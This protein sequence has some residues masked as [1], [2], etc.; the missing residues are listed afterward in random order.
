MKAT[1]MSAKYAYMLS[2]QHSFSDDMFKYLV[3]KYED[4]AL[5]ASKFYYQIW[6]TLD[7]DATQPNEYIVKS[8]KSVFL[9]SNISDI[10]H[11][12]LEELNQLTPQEKTQIN[13]KY[14]TLIN[15]PVESVRDHCTKNLYTLPNLIRMYEARY[16]YLLIPVILDY[17]QDAMLLHQCALLID[18]KNNAVM[19]YEPYGTYIKYDR[20]YLKPMQNFLSIYSDL[21]FQFCSDTGFITQS[22]HTHFAR[23]DGIQNTILQY[24]NAHEAEYQIKLQALLEKVKGIQQLHKALTDKISSNTNP[25]NKTDGTISILYVLDGF[26]E[27]EPSESEHITFDECWEDALDIYYEYNSKTCVSI[28]LTELDY[29]F[30]NKDIGSLYEMYALAE[31][32][33]KVLMDQIF[34]LVNEIHPDAISLHW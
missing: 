27:Y 16:Q 9:E 4:N 3:K 32:P 28:T 20:D 25:V 23:Q 33:N 34:K 12:V 8:T 30:R 2:T 5:V 1:S 15:Q 13:N 14:A 19:F 31:F 17:S 26:E 29:L 18:F 22:F 11:G 6:I 10:E 7:F 21:F 24:N